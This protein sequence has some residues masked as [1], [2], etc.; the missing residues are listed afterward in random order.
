MMKYEREIAVF[1]DGE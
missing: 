1:S